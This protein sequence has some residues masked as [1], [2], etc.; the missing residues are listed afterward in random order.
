MAGGLDLRRAS[1]L[2][3][4]VDVGG[5]KIAAAVVDA[6]GQTFGRIRIP[7]EVGGAEATLNSIADAILQSLSSAEVG[8]SEV[9]AVGLGVPG[10]VDPQAGVGVLSVNLG[11][12]DVPVKAV[13]ESR[14]G[15]PCVL[16]NDVKAATLG[17][18][19]FGAGRGTQNFIYLS[20]GTGIA[21]G[22]ILEGRL[23][24]GSTGMAG[25]VGHAVVDPRG[26]VCKCGTRGCLEAV[27]S[28]PA[29][30]ARAAQALCSWPST[31]LRGAAEGANGL[32]TAE[33]VF[34]AAREGDALA[35]KVVDETS[36]YLALAISQMLMA[37]DPQVIALGGG[38]AQGGGD[39][40]LQTI[41]RNLQGM[42]SESF[43]FREVYEP[44][45]VRLTALGG[46]VGIL[47]AAALAMPAGPG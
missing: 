30:A 18:H 38:V 46:D 36:S 47:G 19:R 37:F 9:L 35:R 32:V 44:Q 31:V 43:V 26:P 22:L 42:A 24:R 10:K 34:E 39:L 27:A 40:L 33:Q 11:W 45:A 7:T 29:I 3:V 6:A 2:V 21:A 28:G 41:R 14:L 13:L 16:E 12:R 17:E 4:G 25:E 20:I 8:K 1:P 15:L 23:Y 5:T